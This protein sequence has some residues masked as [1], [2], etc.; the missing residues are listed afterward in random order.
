M[1]KYEITAIERYDRFCFYWEVEADTPEEAIEEM[2]E[3]PED[4]SKHCDYVGLVEVEKIIDENGEDITEKL[5][6]E[7]LQGDCYERSYSDNAK[8]YFAFVDEQV[9]AGQYR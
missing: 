7:C 5:P 3:L 6:P 1:P 4:D 2:K 9:K 8:A